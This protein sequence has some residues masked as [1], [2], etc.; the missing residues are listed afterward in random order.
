MTSYPRAPR[1]MRSAR[2]RAWSS[3][4]ARTRIIYRATSVTPSPTAAS[5][6]TGRVKQNRA[7]PPG[8]SSIQISW[9]WAARK[10]RAMDRPDP[11]PPAGPAAVEEEED[12]GPLAARHAG[13]LVAH[14]HPYRPSPA[15]G[16][17]TR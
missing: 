3:S 11:G 4:T 14:R 12:V 8:A 9:P 2:S 5:V 17:P 16:G 7:P 1:P 10:A 6:A 15:T 13:A